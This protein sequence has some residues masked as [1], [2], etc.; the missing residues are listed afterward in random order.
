MIVEDPFPQVTPVNMVV[1]DLRVVLNAKNDERF[2]HTPIPGPTRLADTNRVRGAR[3]Y[4]GTLYL[5]FFF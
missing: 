4:N 2:C 5:I 1:T 3:P